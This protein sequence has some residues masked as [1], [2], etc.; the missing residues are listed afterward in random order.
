MP[1]LLL[2]PLVSLTLW[3]VA[4]EGPTTVRWPPWLIGAVAL[5]LRSR[6]PHVPANWYADLTG[7]AGVQPP[8]FLR[9]AEGYAG[10]FHLLSRAFTVTPSLIFAWSVFCS[11][12]AVVVACSAL[13][14]RA[15][16]A[17]RP[18]WRF[19][20]LTWGVLLAVDVR[21]VYLGASDA[22]HNVAFLAFALAL[23]WYGEA[24]DRE[25]RAPWLAFAAA[26]LSATLVG[27]TRPELALSALA[28]PLLLPP[29]APA[30][31]NRRVLPALVL[32]A[33]VLGPLWMW[34][35]QDLGMSL[36]PVTAHHVRAWLA[37][38]APPLVM[39]AV[40]Y[41]IAAAVGRR[42][43]SLALP[44]VA[45]V[46]LAVPR[47]ATDFYLGSIVVGARSVVA[48]FRYDAVLTPVLLLSVALSAGAL[49]ELALSLRHRFARPLAALAVVA[50]VAAFSRRWTDLNTDGTGRF[51]VDPTPYQVEYVFLRRALSAVP[52]GATVV[53]VW[54]DHFPSHRLDP[55]TGL[56]WPATLLAFARPDLHFVTVDPDRPA[57][58][59]AGQWFF[60]GAMCSIDPEPVRSDA[61]PEDVAYI[62]R[63]TGLCRE[64][65]ARVRRRGPS[66]RMAAQGMW[67]PLR[68]GVADLAL[69]EF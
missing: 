44:L 40:T 12:A 21:L 46:A 63:F 42:E 15:D 65:D 14:R 67:W 38:L 25:A 60:R 24:T 53:A 4:S 69:G 36:H 62:G 32:L 18:T 37:G 66:A 68:A 16:R 39:L 57:P 6:S 48:S 56:A 7:P 45:Y 34:F 30:A 8:V 28:V 10:F 5:A 19:A 51:P 3:R 9:R 26:G 17:A 64:L 59:V 47:I 35:D 29:L 43:P 2:V 31:R 33:A 22:P 23:W 61:P 58:V 13:L 20:A 1:W 50:L 54:V 49:C 27:A 52:R 55:D 41:S 11:T